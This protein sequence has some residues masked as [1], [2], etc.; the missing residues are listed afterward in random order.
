MPLLPSPADPT[1]V[2]VPTLPPELTAALVPSDHPLLLLPVRLE[3]RF[4]ALA[5]GKQ[6]LRVR[7]FPDQIHVDSHEPA[8]SADERRWGQHFWEQI[9]RAG[10]DEAT[11]RV[12]WQQL[13]DRFDAQ[14]AAWIA[15][16]LSPTNVADWPSKPVPAGKALLVAPKLGPAPM[17]EDPAGASWQRAPLA[18]AMPQRWIAAATARGALVAHALGAPI[19]REPAVGPDP[20]D[21]TDSLPDQPAIDAG[22]RWMMDF[23]EAEKLGMALRLTMPAA[24]VQQ[25]I[26][27]LAV[28]GVCTLDPAAG[29]QAIASLLDA[30]HYT[31]G[32][33][34]LRVGTPTNNSAEAASGWSSHDPL[35]ARSF[36]T[37][38]RAPQIPI[39]SNADL[40]GRAFGFDA[41]AAHATL[42]TCKD[43]WLTE[44]LDAKQMATASWPA[45]WGYYLTNLIGLEGTGLT[46]EAIS[47]AREH[48]IAHV[49]AFGPL[50]T[51]RVGR[52]PY[53][54]LPVTPLGAPASGIEDARERWLATVLKTLFDRLWRPRVPDAARIG[55]S[56]DPAQDLASVL[57]T[58]AISHSYRLRHLLGP[59]YIEHLRRF[60]GENLSASGWLGAQDTLARAVLNALGFNWHARLEDA[61]YAES[62]LPVNVPL[63]QAGSLDG[64]AA[65]EPNYIA[66][67]LAAP[68]LP[69]TETDA[70]PP[71]SAPATLLHLL[72]RHALQLE[73]TAAAARL[74][75]KQPGAAPLGSLLK[76][77]ELVNLNAATPVT[78]WRMLLSRPHPGTNNVAPA[79]YLAALTK[80]DSPD[81]APLGELRVALAHLQGLEP[82]QLQRLLAGTLD[83]AS[84]RIDAWL[85]SLA[86]RRLQAM[87]ARNATGVRIGGYGWVLNLKPESRQ[88]AVATPPGEAGQVFARADDSGFIHAPSIMQAQAAALL[89]NTH[90][91]HARADA[92]DLFAVDLSSRRVR[93][94][95]MLLDGVRQ[96]QPLGALLGYL[97]ERR[98]HELELDPFIDDFRAAAPLV[99]VNSA[100]DTKPEESIAARNVVDGLKLRELRKNPNAP[101]T[102]AALFAQCAPALDVLEDA[103]DAVADAAIAETAYQ[104]VRGNMVRTGATLQAIASG[105]APPPQLDVVRTPRSGLA[106]T[107]RVV[108]LFNATTAPSSP[109]SP[110]AKAEPQLDA[111]AAKLLG[112]FDRIRFGVERIDAQG[113]VRR[114]AQLRLTALGLAPIDVVYFGPQRPGEP[115]PE[116]DARALAAGATKVGALGPGESLRLARERD[117]TWTPTEMG[118]DELAEL[119]ARVRQ[120]FAVAR[121]LDARD[122][123]SLQHGAEAGTDDKELAK[124]AKAAQSALT[125][126]PAKLKTRLLA[127]T[128]AS[129]TP[130]RNAIAGLSRFGIPGSS[131]QPLADAEALA[132]QGSALASEA[133]RRV[134]RARAASHPTQRL[135]AIFGDSFLALP[136]FAAANAAELAQ[137]LAASSKLQGGTKLAV[138]PWFQRMQRVRESLSQLGA[139]LNAAE[140]AGTGAR[141]ELAVAQ[142]PHIDGDRWLGLA[143]E[144][145]REMPAGRLSLVVHADASLDLAKPL[146]GILVDE[147]VEVV[148]SA[149]E[150]TAIAFQHDA[151][152]SRAPQALL[153]AVP[154]VPGEA[155]TGA[156]LHRLLLDTLAMAQVRALDAE[157]LDTAV[158]NPIAGAQAVGELSHFL[159]ALHF[160]VNADGDAIAPDFRSLMG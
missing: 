76:E 135:Q 126:P 124:R 68:P 105:E 129:K 113:K 100:P 137:S 1:V 123:V 136:R 107:H 46:L 33:G 10:H 44:Q 84:H 94:A 14:R 27:V 7:I 38:C 71:P 5:D 132:A 22:M 3:T 77:R 127:P 15:R 43:A 56:D 120:L 97:F 86:S 160:A 6:E 125:R 119:A 32:L 158:L 40:L 52:Q 81:L 67:L 79:A 99:P 66:A 138:Y 69:Q 149:A 155:W 63:V 147:W 53:G 96:G 42:R 50:P 19:E 128:A 78:T 65:L 122:L 73:Y 29:T 144:P 54:I 60:L 82:E 142:L 21:P 9:W 98:L 25:G 80:F 57:K 92:Q 134:A 133:E 131:P 153:L 12:A 31:L 85:T 118:L 93:L 83:L 48:F 103:V 150:T 154:Q 2:A 89:R 157:A 151:P 64:V 24:V 121:P 74:A 140:A 156:G 61:A 47:W 145:E 59:R 13:A 16:T 51:L 114:A 87:R 20:R 49:R 11:E 116:I 101:A 55:R 70:P 23:N 102:L 30:H 45:T 18:R 109:V 148:P 36:A 75:A 88:T 110:R 95:N 143:A 117:S 159:P 104:A 130:L 17:L 8:L 90:L 106:V 146:A 37:E 41:A 58:D 34:F 152:D 141:M 62:E 108:V 115:M 35:H 111:W 28:F 4:F 26:D 39:G 91:T 139:C 112:P 72:L